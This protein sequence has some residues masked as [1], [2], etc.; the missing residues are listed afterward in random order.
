MDIRWQST[1]DGCWI[2]LAKCSKP[3][4]VNEDRE[5]YKLM[6]WE[7]EVFDMGEEIKK[8]YLSI[9]RLGRL[10]KDLWPVEEFNKHKSDW[11]LNKDELNTGK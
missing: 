11:K 3:F 8:R 6:E 5:R 4:R 10:R 2:Q 9:S 1:R 7:E